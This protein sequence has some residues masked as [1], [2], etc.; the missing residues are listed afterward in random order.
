MRAMNCYIRR[1]I[2]SGLNDETNEISMNH[3][4]FIKALDGFTPASLI[5]VKLIKKFC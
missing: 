1:K 4:D 5:G 2:E 3:G